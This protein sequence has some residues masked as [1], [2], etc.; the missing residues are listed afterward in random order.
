MTATVMRPRLDPVIVCDLRGCIVEANEA[1]SDLLG[2]PAE[3]VIGQSLSRFLPR[4]ELQEFSAAIREVVEHGMVRNMPFNVRNLLGET[5]PVTLNA[6]AL[7]DH[8]Q[9]VIRVIGV[10]KDMRLDHSPNGHAEMVTA[11]RTTR[12]ATD[13]GLQ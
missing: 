2:F 5:I 12:M 7:R 11:A 4:Q 1:V 13:G 6:S 8:N 3:D 10:L 9:K